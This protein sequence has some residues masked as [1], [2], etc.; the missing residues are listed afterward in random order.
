MCG[1]RKRR[2]TE[3]PEERRGNIL[4][5]LYERWTFAYMDEVLRHRDELTT[6]DI[7]PVP[8]SMQARRLV[9]QLEDSSLAR[10]LWTIAAP[11][12]VP[13]GACQLVSVLCQVA[14]PLLVRELLRFKDRS[15]GLTF[16]VSIFFI[17]LIN[18]LCNH[19]HRHLALESGV[20]MRAALITWIYRHALFQQH[21]SGQVANLLAVDAQKLFEVTQEG[22][23]VW[24][25]PLSVVL[26]TGFL[27]WL[28][29]P[30][31]LSEYGAVPPDACAPF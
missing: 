15:H 10:S 7:F 13:A 28:L 14:I 11:T 30:V 12:F 25:L 5:R 23:L 3:W 16:S 20:A 2:Q 4:V 31:T 9:D 6:D 19:R 17:L 29:G 24:A 21:Q 18:A 26:V 1:A 22:H 27:V 8:P